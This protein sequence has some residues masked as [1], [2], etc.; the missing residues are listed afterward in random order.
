MSR[1]AHGAEGSVEGELAYVAAVRALRREGY[2]R[3]DKGLYEE[4]LEA[5]LAR[6]AGQP[7]A[8]REQL[9]ELREAA[10]RVEIHRVQRAGPRRYVEDSPLAIVTRGDADETDARGMS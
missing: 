3:I 10:D 5:H 4:T 6:L 2:A 1:Q 8:A 9:V 7:E